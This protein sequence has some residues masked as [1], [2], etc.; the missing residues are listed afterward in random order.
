[1]ARADTAEPRSSEPRTVFELD[2]NLGCRHCQTIL[3]G[4]NLGDS[5]PNCGLSV[6]ETVNERL[7]FV[8]IDP[9]TM[10]V[11]GDV[12]CGSCGYNLRT[13]SV[14]GRCPECGASVGQFMSIW[15]LRFSSIDWL[16]RIRTGILL[17]VAAMLTQY[18]GIVGGLLYGTFG[19][20]GAVGLFAAVAI[21]LWIVIPLTTAMFCGGIWCATTPED[22]WHLHD[23]TSLSRMASRPLSIFCCP[24]MVIVLCLFR[25]GERDIRVLGTFSMPV[26]IAATAGLAA[27]LMAFGIWLQG[28]ARRGHSPRLAR[29][30]TAAAVLLTTL[31]ILGI[32]VTRSRVCGSDA[33]LVS[34]FVFRFLH[35]PAHLWSKVGSA[36]SLVLLIAYTMA[37]L[38][39]L[40]HCRLFSRYIR[41]GDM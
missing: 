37:T 8:G 5:C 33:R 14:T 15:G 21:N 28:L 39:L 26:T 16:R 9:S 12:P 34:G 20:L 29:R 30:T 4:A 13:L 40:A 32:A 6:R 18:A 11:A 24:M 7:R 1:M 3:D 25:F 41:R 27:G 23:Q 38:G 2:G 19:A 36:L 22:R 17:V 35:L 31:S 10:T